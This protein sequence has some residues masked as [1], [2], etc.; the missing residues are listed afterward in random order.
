MK[1]TSISSGLSHVL[2]RFFGDEPI[3][4]CTMVAFLVICAVVS[5]NLSKAAYRKRE[6]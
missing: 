3:F 6:F 2:N 5:Y 1:E 4:L